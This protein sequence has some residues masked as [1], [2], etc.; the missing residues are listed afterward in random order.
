MIAMPRGEGENLKALGGEQKAVSSKG[1]KKKKV[2]LSNRADFARL[3]ENVRNAPVSTEVRRKEG[4]VGI[5][6]KGEVL[7]KSMPQGKSKQSDL[8]KPSGETGEIEKSFQILSLK[9]GNEVR[10]AN[11]GVQKSPVMDA[12]SDRKKKVT[13]AVDPKL[14]DLI[15]IR[16]QELQHLFTPVGGQKE[17]NDIQVRYKGSERARKFVEET[18][19]EKESF[20]IERATLQNELKKMTPEM[21][22]AEFRKQPPEIHLDI[23]PSFRK[24][25]E[26][27]G[28]R[29]LSG[30]EG[31]SILRQFRETANP[32]ILQQAH[33]FL[34][35]QED[36]EIRLVLK[37]AELGEVKI[38]LQVRERLI[39]GHITVENT[40]V[41]ELF[42][43]NRN[44]LAAS[45]QEQGFEMSQLEVSVGNDPGHKEPPEEGRMGEGIKA[46][47]LERQVPS[48]DSG[49]KDV[50]SLV[51]CYA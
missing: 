51:D 14:K 30:S 37:P 49:W 19:K 36:G 23:S 42:E 28:T 10:I 25:L 46:T 9:E 33:V 18:R 15:P 8:K 32:Q 12:A 50:H 39:E 29:I 4:A 43:Q 21:E 47:L 1:S 40:I 6:P 13:N 2:P 17:E 16:K 24:S 41:R 44:E 31:Q 20:P 35:N 27:G 3:F 26:E 5:V 7:P 38:R 22:K 45:F 48:I 34:R 11:S